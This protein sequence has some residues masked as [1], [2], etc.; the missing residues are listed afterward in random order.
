MA[1]A[2]IDEK[3]PHQ[4]QVCVSPKK[5]R[6]LMVDFLVD[7]RLFVEIDGGF[8]VLAKQRELDDRKEAILEKMGI[9]LLRVSTSTVIRDL[10]GVVAQIK[11]RLASA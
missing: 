7:G 1:R 6:G 10:P 4:R 11:Q 8:H 5:Q 9:P 3:I 2:L